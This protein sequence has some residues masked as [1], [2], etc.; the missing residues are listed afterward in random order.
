[1]NAQFEY[2]GEQLGLLRSQIELRS[3][4]YDKVGQSYDWYRYHE[5]IDHSLYIL[6]RIDVLSRGESKVT[7]S[8]AEQLC[9]LYETWHDIAGELIT[10]VYRNSHES[11][12]TTGL[13]EFINSHGR[14]AKT[15][16]A[17]QKLRRSIA[18]FREGRSVLLSEIAP[19]G[20]DR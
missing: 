1:M 12:F 10:W 6:G 17:I 13:G 14:I 11:F 8:S 15:I 7:L 5:W 2:L 3:S 4:S 19:K 16:T 20:L 18:D 9:N